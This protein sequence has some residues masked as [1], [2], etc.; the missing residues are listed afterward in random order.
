MYISRASG[1]DSWSC[2]QSKPCKSIWRAVALSSHGDSIHLDGTKTDKDPYTCQ[3]GTSDHPGIYINKSLSLI[4]YASPMPQIRC[5]EGRDLTFNGFDNAEQMNVTLSGLLVNESFV[6]FQDS[7]VNI[8]GCKVEGSKQGV[9]FVILN[10]MVLSIQITNSTFSRNRKCI[11]VVVG[12]TKSPSQNIQVEFK[13]TNSSFDSNVLSGEG[14]CISFSESPYSNQSVRCD[15][16]LENVTFTRN[17]FSSKG[18]ILL[19][20]DNGNQ[21]IH[22]QDVTFFD[23]SPSSG[24]DVLTG[25]SDSE[26]IV[27][28]TS[29]NIFIR[30]SNFTSRHARSFLVSAWNSSLQV[31]NCSFFGHRAQGKGGVISLRGTDACKINVSDSSFV[32]TTAAQGGA[33]NIECTNIHSV[34]FQDGIFTDNR[35]RDGGGGAVYIFSS[36]ILLDDA[37]EPK[38]PSAEQLLQINISKCN[39]TNAHSTLRGG[40]LFINALKASMQLR[41]ATF[42]N[43]TVSGG[44]ERGGSGGG[45]V[46]IYVT[47][48]KQ[49]LRNDLLLTV[50]RSCFIRC[51]STDVGGALSVLYKNRIE[52]CVNN[53]YFISNHAVVGGAIGIVSSIKPYKRWRRNVSQLI[54]IEQTTFSNNRGDIGGGAIYID[55]N[56]QSS[57]IIQKVI[58]DSNSAGTYGGAVSINLIFI[59]KINQSCFLKNTASGDVGGALAVSNVNVLVVQDSLFEGNYTWSD[60][61]RSV[62]AGG[63]LS[64]N[65]DLISTSVSIVNTTFKHCSALLEGGAIYLSHKGRVILK[66]KRSRFADNLVFFNEDGVSGYGGGAIFVSALVNNSQLHVKD[67][68]FERNAGSGGGGAVYLT[69]GNATFRNC[70]FVDNFAATLG[71]HIYTTPRFS[72]LIIHDSVFRQT[73]KEIQLLTMNFSKVSF[74]R[75]ES[76]GALKLY[77]T[78]M[79]AQSYGTLN[80]LMQVTNGRLIDFGNDNLTILK[81]PVG[82]RMEINEITFR[83]EGNW[84]SQLPSNDVSTTLQ[85]SCSVC[86]GNSYSLQRGHAIGSQLAPG[87][88]C[89]PC[90]FGANCSQNIIAKP[91]FWG[92]KEQAN[93]PALKFT[94][95]PV[96][97][98]RPPQKTDFPAYNGC[99]GNRTGEICGHCNESFTETLYSTNCR[100]SHEC[101]DYWFWP[102]ALLYVSLMALYFT[103]QPPIVP[104][105]KRQIFWF[106]NHESVEEDRDFDKG[107]LKIIFYFYQ[108]ANLLFV[109]NSAQHVFKT[110]FIKPLIGLF[111]FQQTFSPYGLIC[112]FPGLTVVTKQLFSASHVFGTLLMIGVFFILHWGIH[113]CRGQGAPSVGL[114]IGGVLQTVLL[115]YTTVAS[116]S[117]NLLRCV[118]IGSEKRLFYDGNVVCFQWWQYILIAFICTFFVPFVFT[119][120]WGSFKLHDRT[121]SMGEFLVACSLP[122]PYLLYWTFVC[123]FSRPRN[124]CAGNEDWPSSQMSRSSVER[125]LYDS[126]KRPKDGGKLSLSWESVMIGR[127]LILIVLKAFVSDPMPRLLIMSVFCVLFLLHHSL[128]QPFRDGIANAVETISLLSLGFLAIANMF[129]ASF[130]S[131]AVPLN[132]HFTSWRNACQVVE[133]VILCAVPAVFGLLVVAAVLS[134][135]CRLTVVVSRFL[136]HLFCVCFSWCSMKQDDEMRPL[137]ATVG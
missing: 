67:T 24:R 133:I 88:Q 28:S 17:K 18:L 42:T 29:V 55:T 22:F 136:F 137:L 13:L 95:C 35:A 39:F 49:T 74:V 47:S 135:V 65:C 129:F 96:G 30:S 100:P 113:K 108:A 12:N 121:I 25:D 89:L 64:I 131:L 10:K 125:V 82:C 92:F 80:P 84:L 110:K 97:Y 70:S 103:F 73:M 91:N 68:A 77:N 56:N 32:N 15:T 114:Y 50:I 101:T 76:P 124:A 6:S 19:E 130:L 14:S 120:L 34:N 40:A 4:G 119:L 105:I 43:C 112:P 52:I 45:G 21:N 33:L 51:E 99:H 81:C 37:E 127:R 79:D 117:F 71:G 102:V 26:C 104:W 36:G 122:L 90:P 41:H 111:N 54:I 31:Y 115:G 7:S 5:S 123:L 46:Y 83:N 48:S 59:L 53:S 62:E 57:L 23:N 134:Q 86:A 66:V 85:F 118:P 126:F 109:S 107:Y 128:T 27:R 106:K 63:A 132:D 93:P 94:M 58:M 38:S 3:S 16:T 61:S 78:L 116:V 9:D 1:D 20:I 69:N 11:S 87:F 2:D 98:C 75:A 44:D 72:S 60:I 8:D